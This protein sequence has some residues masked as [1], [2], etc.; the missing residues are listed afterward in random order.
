MSL[1]KSDQVMAIA[2]RNSVESAT[3]EDVKALLTHIFELEDIL[4]EHCDPEDFFGT[5]GWRYRF[6]LED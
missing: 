2:G 5:E 6:G 3:P 4:D 1:L